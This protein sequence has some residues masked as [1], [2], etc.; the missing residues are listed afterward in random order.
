[1]SAYFI[2]CMSAFCYWIILSGCFSILVYMKVH[3]N[4]FAFLWLESCLYWWSRYPDFSEPETT[5]GGHHWHFSTKSLFVRPGG[6][7]AQLVWYFICLI[8]PSRQN[9]V[10]HKSRIDVSNEY[11]RYIN[12]CYFA[13]ICNVFKTM[14]EQRWH[15]IKFI[16]GKNAGETRI[17]L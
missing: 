12:V 13:S 6:S 8:W 2:L 16:C 3:W 5:V 1:M 11:G 15:H 9:W 4:K 14:P 7:G 10:Y 17:N